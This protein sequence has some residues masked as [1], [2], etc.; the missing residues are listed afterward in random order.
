MKPFL[1]ICAVVALVGCLKQE[2]TNPKQ[3]ATTKPVKELTLEE[4]KVVGT[5]ENIEDEDTYRVVL[6]ENGVFEDYLNGDKDKEGKWTINKD[7]EMHVEWEEGNVTVCR[8]N[9]DGSITFIATIINKTRI[10]FPKEEQDTYKII[11]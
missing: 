4:K 3:I 7:G 5:Y 11:K 9:E 8:I 1:L 6:L 2:Q 10:D